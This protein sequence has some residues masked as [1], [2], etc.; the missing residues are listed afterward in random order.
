M[1]C[2]TVGPMF[3]ESDA[4]PQISTGYCKSLP[5]KMFKA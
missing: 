3:S 5:I 2:L 4:D 1:C